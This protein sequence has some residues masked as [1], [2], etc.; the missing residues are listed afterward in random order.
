MTTSQLSTKA[1]TVEL[2]ISQ[3]ISWGT[4]I[5]G[6]IVDRWETGETKQ[7]SLSERTRRSEQMFKP[8]D[9]RCF[10]CVMMLKWLILL[11][12]SPQ[13]ENSW[14]KTDCFCSSASKDRRDSLSLRTT[15]TKKG[16]LTGFPLQSAEGLH[17]DGQLPSLWKI[18]TICLL[19]V[20]NVVEMIAFVCISI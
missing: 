13:I 4:M 3:S 2:N 1:K 7:V 20:W 16:S 11:L 17:G 8:K 19:T 12:I 9:S 5:N 10:T 15:T 14:E 18:A 6:Q